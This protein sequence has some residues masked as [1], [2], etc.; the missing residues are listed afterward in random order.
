VAF[1][2]LP[3]FALANTGVVLAG[4]WAAGLL[5]DNS[6]GIMLGL[7]VGKPAGIVVFSLLGVAVGF[8]TLPADISKATLLGAGL[9]AGIGFTMSIF[10]TL[11][12]FPVGDLVLN[13]KIAVL[14]ASVLAGVLGFAVLLA[15]LRGTPLAQ[16]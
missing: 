7:V 10:I 12:A 2:I 15:S 14:A 16:E 6:L 3:L 11:L 4:A 8:Y 5:S 9:L 1:V 13:S